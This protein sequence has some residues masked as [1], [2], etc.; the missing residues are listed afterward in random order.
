MTRH[1][2]LNRI[3]TAVPQHDVHAKFMDFVPRML[4]DE[5]RRRLLQRMGERAQIDHRYS[6]LA[7]HAD[8]DQM[9][10]GEQFGLG[11][12]ADTATRMAIFQRHAPDLAMQAIGRLA[13][14]ASEMPTH[15]VVTTCTGQYAP[16]LDID[17]VRRLNLDTAVERTVIGFM[18]CYAAINGLKLAHHVVRSDPTARVL[19][20]NLETCTLH[21]QHI[22]DLEA[23]LSF[24][25][26]ADGC[27][28]S[29]I[30]AEP[31]GGRIEG[32]HSGILPQS[33]EQILW[34]VGQNGFDIRLSGAVPGSIGRGLPGVMANVRQRFG[35]EF[36]LWA[37]HPGG[38]T[39]L[40]AAE[41]ALELD[42]SALAGSREVLRR[43][44]NM[45]SAAIMF[46][47]QDAI[48][49]ASGPE[50]GVAMAFGPGLTAE[51]MVFETLA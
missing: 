25:V 29:L 49:R 9:Y 40:D 28:A 35:D 22:D 47:L 32:F 37:V 38:R 45:S 33:E 34:Q 13:L 31:A 24:M 5:R 1:A 10:V 18:G 23:L 17:I 14:T 41:E 7:P 2:Y 16:G 4:S 20:L 19:M 27:A 12:F 48:E 11:G 30:S 46:A 42:R 21:L 8:P 36:R 3:A 39:I 44:G 50:R 51:T 6:V 43:Y 15:V 26:F